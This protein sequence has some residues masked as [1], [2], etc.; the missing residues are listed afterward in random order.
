[1]YHPLRYKGLFRGE[2]PLTIRRAAGRRRQFAV[3]TVGGLRN[4]RYRRIAVYTADLLFVMKF[5]VLERHSPRSSHLYFNIFHIS[6]IPCY[7][8]LH[9]SRVYYSH[10]Q[11]KGLRRPKSADRFRLEKYRADKHGL[12][13]RSRQDGNSRPIHAP[14]KYNESFHIYLS[15]IQAKPLC[16]AGRFLL[17]STLLLSFCCRLKI[18]QFGAIIKILFLEKIPERVK[19]WDIYLKQHSTSTIFSA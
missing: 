18:L 8:P 19:T 5:A 1:M 15:I 12:H 4:L 11:R 2:S 9:K 16:N 3:L 14:P 17:Y 10:S 13:N 7:Y 6:F